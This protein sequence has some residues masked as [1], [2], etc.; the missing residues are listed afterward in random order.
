MRVG[1]LEV[2]EFFMWHDET[3][4]V[5]RRNGGRTFGHPAIIREEILGAEIPFADDEEVEHVAPQP[6]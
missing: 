5:M 3:M 1:D 2:G 4:I 6:G